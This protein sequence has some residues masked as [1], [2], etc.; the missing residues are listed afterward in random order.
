[1]R[2]EKKLLGIKNIY[3]QHNGIS[4]FLTEIIVSHFFFYFFLLIY[5]Y[6]YF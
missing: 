1:M 6:H 4:P 2:L 3:L 5:T